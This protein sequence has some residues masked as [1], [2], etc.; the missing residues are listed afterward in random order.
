MSS[1]TPTDLT[2]AILRA[3]EE[4]GACATLLLDQAENPR[5]ILVESDED[6][7]EV[8]IYADVL[9]PLPRGTQIS[10][11]IR[12]MTLMSTIHDLNLEGPTIVVGY[13]PEFRVFVEFD[14]FG[15]PRPLEGGADVA[16]GEF[17]LDEASRHGT[18]IERTSLG[19]YILAF[20]QDHLWN[21]VQ[22]AEEFSDWLTVDEIRDLLRASASMTLMPW[23]E[24][25][26]VPVDRREK[27]RKY[28]R[29][30]LNTNFRYAVRNAYDHRCAITG[31]RLRLNDASHIYPARFEDSSYEVTNGILL[32]PTYHRA[33]DK[34]LIFLDENHNMKLNYGEEKDLCEMGMDDGLEKI[35][36]AVGKVPPFMP[37]DKT[38]WP[39]REMIQ[40]GNITRRVKEKP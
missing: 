30:Q 40:K 28:I 10:N 8:W 25:R 12:H 33:F 13:D 20:R 27:A 5:K 37:K 39:T 11:P 1:F 34:S 32:Q 18:S 6:T 38:K 23:K 21:Y 35:K 24:I 36:S 31:D 9:H 7:I 17:V 15:Y 3:L 26:R 29:S 14:T 2:I 22:H 16:I 19:S 4:S